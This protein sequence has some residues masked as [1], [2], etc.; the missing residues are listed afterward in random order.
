MPPTV[1]YLIDRDGT[2]FQQL[3]D[4]VFARHVIGLNHCTIGV[5]NVGGGKDPL[6]KAQLK[7]KEQLIRYLE[8]AGPPN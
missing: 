8:L 2:I 6:T 5:E 3:P 1:H 7:A 4:T